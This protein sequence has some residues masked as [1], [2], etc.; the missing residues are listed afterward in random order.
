MS[1]MNL[2]KGNFD[3]IIAA[4]ELVVIDFWAEWCAPCR[5]FEPIYE[6]I[7]NNHQNILFAKVNIEEES[8]LAAEFTIRSIPTLMILRQKIM[9]FC[10]SGLLP[11]AA[12]E[13]L[14]K[15]AQLLNMDEVRK[16]LQ[17]VE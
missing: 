8:E 7:A 5:S 9:V 11:A 6:Q 13:D 15:Q 10:E 4:N 12:V 1:I 17:E 16:Q 2:T 14:L 3:Q